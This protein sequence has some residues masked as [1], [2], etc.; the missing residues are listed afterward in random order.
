MRRRCHS[1]WHKTQASSKQISETPGQHSSAEH[2]R[3]TS[4]QMATSPITAAAAGQFF[5]PIMAG[6]PLHEDVAPAATA[7]VPELDTDLVRLCVLHGEEILGQRRSSGPRE[8]QRFHR[9][10]KKSWKS[11][12]NC[13]R[14]TSEVSSRVCCGRLRGLILGVT[15]FLHTCCCQ[16]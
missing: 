3:N 7:G 13:Y 5:L 12:D 10:L 2:F 11:K 6:I 14:S 9:K 1:G 8:R 16:C 15:I 4:N